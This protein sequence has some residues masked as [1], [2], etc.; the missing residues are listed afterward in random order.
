MD[1]QEFVLETAPVLG[2]PDGCTMGWGWETI[3]RFPSIA[4]SQSSWYTPL[5]SLLTSRSRIPSQWWLFSGDWRL[6]LIDMNGKELDRRL[7]QRIWR[8]LPMGLED[9]QAKMVSAVMDFSYMCQDFIQIWQRAPDTCLWVGERHTFFRPRPGFWNGKIYNTGNC[10]TC[11]SFKNTCF[12][13]I[14]VLPVCISVHLDI[15]LVPRRESDPLRLE[16]QTVVSCRRT[17]VSARTVCALN[18]WDFSPAT[19]VDS[20]ICSVVQASKT[21]KNASLWRALWVWK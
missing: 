3:L 20:W 7:L 8:P 9:I 19:H 4:H 11:W 10:N 16:L 15:S 17:G 14:D 21:P 6:V 13:C 12:M 5:P 1:G 18:C 2:Y